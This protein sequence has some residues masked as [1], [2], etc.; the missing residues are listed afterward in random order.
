MHA[1]SRTHEELLSELAAM[2]QR[3]ADLQDLAAEHQQIRAALEESTRLLALSADVGTA[4]AG[5]DSLRT[6]L[7]RCAEALVEHLN[8]A[9]A[10]IWTLGE[11]DQMLEMQASAGIYLHLDGPHGYVPIGNSEIGLIA[12]ERHPYITHN[13]LEDTRIRDKAWAE[14]TGLVA[15]AGYPLTVED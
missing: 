6:I 1:E 3:M 14:R 12:Q 5:S 10:C 11:D 13:V 7:Q 2:H 15:F 8:A 4:L 9:L